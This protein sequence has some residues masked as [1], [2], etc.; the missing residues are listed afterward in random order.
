MSLLT[1][2][3]AATD[4]TGTF[5]MTD[6]PP[7]AHTIQASHEE[8]GILTQSVTVEAGSIATAHFTYPPAAP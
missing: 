5:R 2:Y 1:P 8:Y 4:L 7:G 3:F 6:V